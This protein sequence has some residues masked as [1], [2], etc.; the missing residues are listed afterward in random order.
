MKA[1][2]LVLGLFLPFITLSQDV[3][4]TTT[5]QPKNELGINLFSVTDWYN[6]LDPKIRKW[7]ASLPIKEVLQTNFFSGI[8]YKRHYGKNTLRTSLEYFQKTRIDFSSFTYAGSDYHTSY[9]ATTKT[10][11]VKI[12]YERS[13]GNCK[14]RPYLF[15]DAVFGYSIL[16]GKSNYYIDLG[17][18]EIRDEYFETYSGGTAIGGGLSY[19]V[20]KNIAFT[21]EFSIESRVSKSHALAYPREQRPTGIGSYH[22]INPVRQLGLSVLF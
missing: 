12:G 10:G 4:K 20:S 16:K 5:T 15:V 14:L 9:A 6:A 21:Y 17:Q 8:Y 1:S 19:K 13:F 2:I 18:T 7:Q 11:E 22:K 3:E